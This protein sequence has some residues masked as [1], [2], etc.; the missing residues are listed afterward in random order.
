MFGSDEI[1]NRIREKPFRPFRIVASGRQHFDIYHPD[2]LLVGA[3]ELT[4]GHP[5]RGV[6]GIYGK[7]TRVA[8]QHIV[9]LED[10]P[11]DR[12]SSTE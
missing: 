8:L 5:H 10:L 12:T 1:L 9:A 3:D 11:L 7:T 2:L 4:I 6:A